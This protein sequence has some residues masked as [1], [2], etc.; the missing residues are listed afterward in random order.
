[1]EGNGQ[2]FRYA[3]ILDQHPALGLVMMLMI[4]IITMMMI[5]KTFCNAFIYKTICND[6]LCLLSVFDL[7]LYTDSLE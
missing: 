4:I 5:E 3:M 7:S 6:I 1:M 2:V